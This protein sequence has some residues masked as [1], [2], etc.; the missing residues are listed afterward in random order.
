MNQSESM[1]AIWLGVGLACIGAAIT[2]FGGMPGYGITA[3]FALIMLVALIATAVVYS[4]QFLKLWQAINREQSKAKRAPE[5]K[6]KL[7]RE[8]LDD[9]EW[10]SFKATLKEQVLAGYEADPTAHDGELPLAAQVAAQET[11][12]KQ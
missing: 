6:I 1:F 9:D 12:Q 7:L 5:D 11:T 4:E 8:M 2:V 3:L 10:E